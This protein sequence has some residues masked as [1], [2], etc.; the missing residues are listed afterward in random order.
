MNFNIE[1][2]LIMDE[3]GAIRVKGTRITID[4]IIAVF[5]NG[6]SPETIADMFPTLELADVYSV[7]SFYLQRRDEVEDYLAK[8]ERKSEALRAEMERRFPSNGLRERLLARKAQL[9]GQP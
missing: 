1:T 7:L 8:R 5:R 6:A 9:E 3:H 4:T 2:P